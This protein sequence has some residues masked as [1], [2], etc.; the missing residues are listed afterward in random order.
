MTQH[1]EI[2]PRNFLDRRDEIN[3]KLQAN[4]Q[5]EL[6][7]AL[8]VFGEVAF[9]ACA[10]TGISETGTPLK[11]PFSV[12]DEDLGQSIRELLLQT[13]LHPAP[14]YI[15][16]KLSDWPAYI[17]SGA[18]SGR[19]FEE[20]STY[21]SIETVNTALRLHASRR[22]PTSS[23]YIGQDHSLN[24]DSDELGKSIRKLVSIVRLLDSQNAL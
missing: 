11:L 20:K 5:I 24:V 13:Y 18:K 6:R 12:T 15:D 23:V 4:H 9:I 7:V 16:A 21:L 19:A 8:Y 1:R 3:A 10:T 22:R 2:T 14:S 17:A